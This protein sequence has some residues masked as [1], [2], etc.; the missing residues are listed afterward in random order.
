MAGLSRRPGCG[1]QGTTPMT[2]PPLVLLVVGT[3]MLPPR[4]ERLTSQG[5]LSTIRLDEGIGQDGCVMGRS[6]RTRSK[7]IIMVESV[8]RN[9]AH[10]GKEGVGVG[11]TGAAGGVEEEG[12]DGDGSDGG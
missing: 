2:C 4:R 11:T 6:S 8:I 9:T 12:D 7:K 1:G 10:R 3:S 5:S